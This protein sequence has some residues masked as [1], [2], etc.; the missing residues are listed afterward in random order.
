MNSQRGRRTSLASPSITTRGA[1]GR[2]RILGTMLVSL[3][4]LQSSVWAGKTTLYVSPEGNDL[5]S[6]RLANSQQDDGPL[7]SLDAARLKIRQ[8]KAVDPEGSFE[9]QLRGG[10]Y[11]LRETVVFGPEDSGRKEAPIVY[12]AYPGEEPVFT[13]GVPVSGWK[14]LSTYPEG[15]AEVAKGNLWVADVPQGVSDDW[16]IRSLYDGE[17]LL[18]RSRSNS[19]YYQDIEKKNDFNRQG[20]KLTSV[21]EYEGAPVAPFDRNIFYRD[22]DLKE[23]S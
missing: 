23:W 5:W 15:V 22:D 19:L 14:K 1:G 8:L 16:H 3:V 11:S 7:A 9:V 2:S 18:K 17:V 4:L 6:G 20:K 21:L 10:L 12:K 13:G